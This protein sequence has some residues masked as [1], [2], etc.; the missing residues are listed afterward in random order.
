MG[1]VLEIICLK[2]F[3]FIAK[4]EK[5]NGGPLPTLDLKVPFANLGPLGKFC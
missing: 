1:F 3:F 2:L 5:P 4:G